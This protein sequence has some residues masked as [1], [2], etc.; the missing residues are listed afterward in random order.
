MQFTPLYPVSL[1]TSIH[2]LIFQAF[3]SRFTNEILYAYPASS[4]RITRL[5]YILLDLNL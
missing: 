2:A 5:R 3:P 1:I 4:I